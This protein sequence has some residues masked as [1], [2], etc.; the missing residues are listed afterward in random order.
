MRKTRND[1]LAVSLT[2][3]SCLLSEVCFLLLESSSHK[4]DHEMLAFIGRRK[5]HRWN[6]EVNLSLKAWRVYLWRC[7]APS[8]V[9]R[10][11]NTAPPFLLR[12]LLCKSGDFTLEQNKV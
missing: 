12:L 2:H 10:V 6:E 11:G 7:T 8:E 5:A 3:L 1:F 9:P 4:R